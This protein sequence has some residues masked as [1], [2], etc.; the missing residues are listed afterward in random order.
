MEVNININI[1]DHAEIIIL[2]ITEFICIPVN[3]YNY[4]DKLVVH[5]EE[6]VKLKT[7]LSRVMENTWWRVWRRHQW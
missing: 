4:S 3:K 6:R 5:I 7:A 1:L 2:L